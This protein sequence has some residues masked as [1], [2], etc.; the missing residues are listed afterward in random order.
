MNVPTSRLDVAQRG[1]EGA[2]RVRG[3]EEPVLIEGAA[4]VQVDCQPRVG[5]RSVGGQGAPDGGR[6]GRIIWFE[7]IAIYGGATAA[8][9][10]AATAATRER[11]E[12]D[13][14]GSAEG[15]EAGAPDV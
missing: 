12:L 15:V 2:T 5:L 7:N 10:A 8:T 13:Q 6:V 3:P 9:T 11:G 1:G 14:P 4:R